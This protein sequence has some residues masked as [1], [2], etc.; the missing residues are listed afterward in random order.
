[1]IHRYTIKPNQYDDSQL[2]VGRCDTKSVNLIRL[3]LQKISNRYL[4]LSFSLIRLRYTISQGILCAWRGD[5]IVSLTCILNESVTVNNY[6]KND[7]Y[8]STHNALGTLMFSYMLCSSCGILWGKFC[9]RTCF[10]WQGT[11][12]CQQS[13]IWMRDVLESA[14]YFGHFIW[15]NASCICS[16]RRGLGEVLNEI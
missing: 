6:V 11:I 9:C 2:T 1:M 10:K 4:M 8:H 14:F 15:V 16:L 3:Y 12:Y 13:V 7:G 5:E